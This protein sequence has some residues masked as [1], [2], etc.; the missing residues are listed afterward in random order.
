[1][2]YD[3]LDV[4]VVFVIECAFKHSFQFILSHF[5]QAVVEANALL[6]SLAVARA[7]SLLELYDEVA[8]AHAAASFAGF[9]PWHCA[10]SVVPRV[11]RVAPLLVNVAVLFKVSK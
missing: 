1:M 9:A 6:A 4:A 7:L 10:F 11:A 5:L 8:R 3:G 2:E